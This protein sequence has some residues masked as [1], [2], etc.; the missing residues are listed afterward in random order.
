MKMATL[1]EMIITCMISLKILK[2]ELEN[3]ENLNFISTKVEIMRTKEL[4]FWQKEKH[5]HYGLI[6]NMKY[7]VLKWI[8][9]LIFS[10]SVPGESEDLLDPVHQPVPV[11]RVSND[12]IS[13][14]RDVLSSLCA[15]D[16]C[17]RLS[18]IS[19]G[20]GPLSPHPKAE[21][22]Q[23][24]AVIPRAARSE[25]PG[26][27]EQRSPI[28]FIKRV[29]RDLAGGMVTDHI[30]RVRQLVIQTIRREI[31][32]SSGRNLEAGANCFRRIPIGRER[33]RKTRASQAEIENRFTETPDASQHSPGRWGRR[34]HRLQLV[35]NEDQ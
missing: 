17:S 31:P 27:H 2:S 1:I 18:R 3:P 22:P 28:D 14:L 11:T 20:L 13:S 32:R 24:A 10:G 16:I 33:S 23:M 34:F 19:P 4:H 12:A 30:R 29:S 6:G 5:Y 25:P 35:S 15:D 8:L 26:V 21:Q 7:P 9:I